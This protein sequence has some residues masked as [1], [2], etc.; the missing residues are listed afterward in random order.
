M[1]S[2]ALY[3][4]RARVPGSLLEGKEQADAVKNFPVKQP[5]PESDS[6]GGGSNPAVN[7]VEATNTDTSKHT[8]LHM[9][10]WKVE[11]GKVFLS[12]VVYFDF[13]IMF[14][15]EYK[16]V[17]LFLPFE[18]DGDPIDLSGVLRSN[19]QTLGAVFNTDVKVESSVND[20]FCMVKIPKGNRSFYLYKLG[21]TNFYTDSFKDS[22]RG[23]FIK[24]TINS[25]PKDSVVNQANCQ[26]IY[27]RFRVKLKDNS[28][29]II[30][31]HISNDLLQDAFSNTDLFDVRVNESRVIE[32]KVK[33]TMELNNFEVCK[34]EKVHLFYMT[35]TQEA[36]QNGSSLNQDTRLLEE[37][38]W[39]D[40]QPETSLHG[41]TFVAYHWKKRRKKWKSENEEKEDEPI[42]SFSVFFN[43]IYPKFHF[44]RLMA[45]L[46][47]VVL[48][49]WLGSMLTFDVK[50]GNCE[51]W[52]S[53][54]RPG[55]IIL[56]L[57]YVG[58]FAVATKYGLTWLKI[59]RKR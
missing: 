33:E 56:T 57:A 29:Y 35:D 6:K 52:R 54:V 38:Q 9:N 17:C 3:Y 31:E 53:C 49:G 58:I 12:P 5:Q 19:T 15:I 14:P 37:D 21:D 11:K 18:M 36:V 40:Y 39:Q 59:Y 23:V 43:V 27:V 2:I 51:D 32:S 13:G 42:E 22:P 48:L 26:Q 45:Y 16:T 1:K 30:S 8:E 24:I 47:T 55:V 7:G 10:I 20:N 41:T 28:Q 46:L 44:F 4:N 50:D 34:F 25:D